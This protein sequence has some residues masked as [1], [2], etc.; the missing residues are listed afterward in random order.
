MNYIILPIVFLGS[1][2]IIYGLV[3]AFASKKFYVEV[4]PKIEQI[5]EIL[6][7]ANCGAC[8]YPGCAGY[9]EAI[10]NENAP[11]SKCPPSGEETIKKLLKLWELKLK[12]LKKVLP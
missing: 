6:P 12:K 5:A 4:N 8:G 1:L 10:V 7:N 11:I 9:A 2:A 3:L